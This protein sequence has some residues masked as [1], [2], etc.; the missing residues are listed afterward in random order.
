M[1]EHTHEFPV[2]KMSSVLGVSRSGY[3]KW[4]KR[5]AL[6]ASSEDELDELIRASFANSRKTYGSPRVFQD[7]TNKGVQ[8]SEATVARRM[9]V[10]KLSPMKPKRW[11]RTTQS[12][13]DNPVAAN[14]LDRNFEA[15]RPATKWVS[16]IS[17]FEVNRCWFYLT[18]ILDLA[19]RAIVGW[20]ISEDMSADNTTIAALQKAVANR[21]PEEELIFHSDRGVQ[22]TCGRMREE[23]SAIGAVQS[24]SRKGNCWDNAVAESFFKTIKTECIHHHE[25]TSKHH[26]WSVIFDYMEGWYNTKR[27]HTTLKGLTVR[28]AYEAKMKSNPAA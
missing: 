6:T 14:L 15:V 19:D 13:H 27:L 16:D 3:Y 7:L 26:A 4:L 22:Y 2:L 18:I 5:G 25:F 20:V 21:K 28:Q 17:Y 9:K 1:K 8:T 12:K 11:V 23:I 24:M 10:L